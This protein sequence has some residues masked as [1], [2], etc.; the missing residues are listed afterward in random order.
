[1]ATTGVGPLLREWRD[2]RGRS[3]LA[4]ALEVG[5]STRHLSCVETG[6]SRP[7]PELVLALGRHLDVPLRTQNQMLLAAGYAPRYG[8]TPLDSPTLA[9]VRESLQRVLDAHDPYPGVLIDRRWDVVGSNRAA[10]A[11]TAGLPDHLTQPVVNVFRVCLHPDGLAA[12]TVD[13]EPWA[14]YLLDQL[15][16]VAS[17][18]GPGVAEL[19]A[20]VSGYPDLP[21]R[22]GRSRDVPSS[23][24]HDDPQIVVP[25]RLTVGEHV[26]S[27]FTTLTTFGTP[28]DVTL[29]ELAIEL[30]F[31]ADDATDDL[32]RGGTRA[33]LG[34]EAAA[35]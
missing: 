35:R 4:L 7:S 29:D 14:R 9:R 26:L 20:E 34:V 30:F 2:R 10:A 15:R 3:Q 25:F 27:M 22:D 12:R 16:R 8:H 28:Q 6:R 21:E 33:V 23:G 19:V 18:G 24:D 32:L 11:L 17:A 13:F 1:M 5:V 31:P